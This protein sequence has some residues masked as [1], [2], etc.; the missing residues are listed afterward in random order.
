MKGGARV[1]PVRNA[2][3]TSRKQY[4]VHEFPDHVALP[5]WLVDDPEGPQAR[6]VLEALNRH[7]RRALLRRIERARRGR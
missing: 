6:R 7:D 3:Q 1:S 5:E 4:G 2:P